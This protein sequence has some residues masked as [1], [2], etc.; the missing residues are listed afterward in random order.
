[1]KKL[2]A[3]LLMM[4]IAG[5]TNGFSQEL[6]PNRTKS[7]LGL[8]Y[9]PAI[10]LNS[11]LVHQYIG[12]HDVIMFKNQ[13]IYARLSEGIKFYRPEKQSKTKTL[14]ETGLEMGVKLTKIKKW[15][16]YGCG[17]GGVG[18]GYSNDFFA[19]HWQAGAKGVLFNAWNDVHLE[20]S[21]RYMRYYFDNGTSNG[22]DN[23]L[24]IGVA[25]EL[26]EWRWW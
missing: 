21:L 6:S 14:I 20:V 3:F 13:K 12:I 24:A 1:M 16:I 25:V 17:G 4:S 11:G 23:Q 10:S 15:N 2:G 7:L 22:T 5:C 18:G 9:T 8:D 19:G 26:F